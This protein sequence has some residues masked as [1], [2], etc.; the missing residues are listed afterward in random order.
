MDATEWRLIYSTIDASRFSAMVDLMGTRRS[1]DC[2]SG[3]IEASI[4]YRRW[5]KIRRLTRIAEDTYMIPCDFLLP[6]HS[7]SGSS[8]HLTQ[9]LMS[10]LTLLSFISTSF[11][12]LDHSVSSK[13]TISCLINDRA[14]LLSPITNFGNAI[15]SKRLLNRSQ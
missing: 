7:L 1:T 10:W 9:K 4:S 6:F 13:A 3:D 5:Y 8:A 15:S 11:K 2:L 14:S 12:K